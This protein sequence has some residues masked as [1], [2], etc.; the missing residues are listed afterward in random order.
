M[1]RIRQSLIWD[2]AEHFGETALYTDQPYA[3]TCK[4]EAPV[5]LLALD[6]PTFDELVATSRLAAHYVE[7][8]S[9]GR[10]LDTR[11]KLGLEAVIS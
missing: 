11:R 1:A 9:T 3:A 7:Q 6:E 2:V 8:V 10:T 5:K 4:A